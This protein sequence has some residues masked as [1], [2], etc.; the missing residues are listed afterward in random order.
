[1]TYVDS[2]AHTLSAASFPWAELLPF[3]TILF[4]AISTFSAVFFGWRVDRRQTRELELKVKELEL[5]IAEAST[6]NAE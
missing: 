3:A 5:K 1:M 4:T 2:K 6:R